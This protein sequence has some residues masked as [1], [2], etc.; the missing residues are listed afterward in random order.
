[1]SCTLQCHAAL[2]RL[3]E[4]SLAILLHMI[5]LEAMNP[6]FFECCPWVCLIN[7]CSEG[8]SSFDCFKSYEF[9][10]LYMLLMSSCDFFGLCRNMQICYDV[11]FVNEFRETLG[12][13]TSNQTT[14][15]PNSSGDVC[16]LRE[17]TVSI[18]EWLGLLVIIHFFRVF[19]ICF[20]VTRKSLYNV[21]LQNMTCF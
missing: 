4:I 20:T 2:T 19:S 1:M 5:V 17:I 7:D 15:P 3:I 8:G 13:A 14:P 6:S 21:G 9:P 18:I 16:D 10:C 11:T 12:R